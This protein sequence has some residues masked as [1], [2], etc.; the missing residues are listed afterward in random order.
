MGRDATI[1]FFSQ[2]LIRLIWPT[3]RAFEPAG[4]CGITTS[5]VDNT[6]SGAAGIGLNASLVDSAEA[7]FDA[8]FDADVKGLFSCLK[9]QIL[10]MRHRGG[11]IVNITSAAA[12]T[13]FAYNS[14]CNASKNAAAMLTKTA[15]VEAGKHN[16]RIIEVVPGPIKTPMLRGYFARERREVLR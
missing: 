7:E 5:H 10:A 15:A 8:I 16:I 3:E 9:R 4:E 6:V 14:L 13:P 11:V 2:V 1:R 12:R